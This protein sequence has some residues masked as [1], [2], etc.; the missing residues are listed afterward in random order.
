MSYVMQNN[1]AACSKTKDINN[2]VGKNKVLFVML[3]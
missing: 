1:D 3:S 2:F